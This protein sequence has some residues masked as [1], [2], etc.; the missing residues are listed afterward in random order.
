MKLKIP[1]SLVGDRNQELEEAFETSL[2]KSE[3]ETVSFD[4][5]MKGG[6]T[7]LKRIKNVHESMAESFYKGRVHRSE[8]S[9]KNGKEF[10]VFEMTGYWNG[11]ST[12]ESWVKFFTVSGDLLY[13]CLIRFPEADRIPT[14]KYRQEI[15][16]SLEIVNE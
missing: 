4:I 2:L 10:Y 5:K 8:I 14:E 12:K 9:K 1:A 11:S 13:Q 3:D 15:V 16:E 6:E 7:N